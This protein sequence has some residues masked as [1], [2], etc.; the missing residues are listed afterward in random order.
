MAFEGFLRDHLDS[1]NS[2]SSSSSENTEIVT[3]TPR[4]IVCDHRASEQK[5][6]CQENTCK[7]CQN[8]FKNQVSFDRNLKC[9]FNNNCSMGKSPRCKK[10]R[11]DRCLK[12][13]NPKQKNKSQRNNL[14]PPASFFHKDLN[15]IF[16]K[17]TDLSKVMDN[18]QITWPEELN[19]LHNR[20][21]FTSVFQTLSYVKAFPYFVSLSLDDQKEVMYITGPVVTI[22]TDAFYS[23]IMN[24]KY[25]QF[26]DG[27]VPIKSRVAPKTLDVEIFVKS[28]E[29]MI[30]LKLTNEEF[31]LLKGIIF[32]SAVSS[33]ISSCG[34]KIL[35][36]QKDNYS[37]ILLEH[38]RIR[39]GD[40]HGPIKFGEIVLSLD[41]LFKYA[42]KLR[43][44]YLCE[45]MTDKLCLNDTQKDISPLVNL[46]TK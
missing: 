38:L 42:D 28:V 11:L 29:V 25:M 21:L 10:C 39:Y 9:Q 26:P 8:F 33:R 27:M 3:P 15:E 40:T 13:M 36:H 35:S 45:T 31:W 18:N 22:M 43:S 37:G 2:S 32:C 34:R 6:Y 16:L 14:Y 4:C 30:R 17:P 19:N 12:V 20:R 7:S 23:Y 46:I 1:W 44:W 5:L 41:F 24:L